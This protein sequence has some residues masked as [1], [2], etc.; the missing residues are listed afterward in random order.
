MLNII[1]QNIIQNRIILNHSPYLLPRHLMT[2]N[3]CTVHYY[4]FVTFF[5]YLDFGVCHL[6][7]G[8]NTKVKYNFNF[9]Y[10]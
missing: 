10:R 5:F 8:K 1:K 9:K 3:F 7:K 2:P 4:G 6:Y